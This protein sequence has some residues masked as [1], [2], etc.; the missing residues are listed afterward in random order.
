MLLAIMPASVFGFCG[1]KDEQWLR[2]GLWSKHHGKHA[3]KEQ[4]EKHDQL[5][6]D[7]GECTILTYR[8]SKSRQGYIA[9]LNSKFKVFSSEHLDIN[10]GLMY[11]LGYFESSEFSG[12]HYDSGFKPAAL[13]IAQFEINQTFSVDVYHVGLIVG[14]LVGAKDTDVVTAVGFRWKF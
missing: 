4:N 13:W 2:A 8:D 9:A 6:I 11:G 10:L 3:A 7:Y 14:E 5:G 1:D 12:K